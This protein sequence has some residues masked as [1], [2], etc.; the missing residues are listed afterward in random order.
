MK[1]MVLNKIKFAVNMAVV[2]I[3]LHIAVII[4]VFFSSCA[5]M[6]QNNRQSP[7]IIQEQG[8]FAVGGKV[9]TNPGVFDPYNPAP[10][11]QTLHGDHAYVFYQIPVKACKLPLIFWHGAGQFS[12]T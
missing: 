12:K 8:S 4:T 5:V 1:K 3:S 2:N 11:G 7:L 6:K 9:I 10:E